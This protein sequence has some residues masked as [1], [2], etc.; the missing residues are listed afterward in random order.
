[1]C[2]LVHSISAGSFVPNSQIRR[3]LV[4]VSYLPLDALFISLFMAILV[5]M[6]ASFSFFILCSTA[7]FWL[8]LLYLCGLYGCASYG[9]SMGGVRQVYVY[10]FSLSWPF[11]FMLQLLCFFILVNSLVFIVFFSFFL[12]FFRATSRRS[13]VVVIK[14]WLLSNCFYWL[15]ELTSIL[16][17][18]FLL[19]NSAW[20]TISVEIPLAFFD[21]KQFKTIVAVIRNDN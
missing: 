10:G 21:W 6:F 7:A 3:A 14:L 12:F 20:S 1:M 11:C 5:F 2:E 16:P 17:E 8:S 18:C 13:F 15:T 19:A 9:K 4:Y